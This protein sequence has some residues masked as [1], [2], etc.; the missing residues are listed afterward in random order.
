MKY[1]ILISVLFLLTLASALVYYY[2]PT[3]NIAESGFIAISSVMSGET[4]SLYKKAD[5]VIEFKF[6]DDYGA[7][8]EY[9]L[10][11]WYFTGNLRSSEGKSF[12][13]QFTIF[14]NALSPSELDIESGLASNQVYFAHI[15]ISD[16]DAAQHHHFEKFARGNG[17]LAGSSFDPLN[18]FV[19]NWS[20]S[21]D[22][23]NNDY[24]KPTF[25]INSEI[26]G[27]EIQLNLKPIKDMVL[28]GNN[29]LSPKSNEP[30]NAS[31]YYSFTRIATE[32]T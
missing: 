27:N 32:G 17:K 3:A 30:G 2:I 21:G 31:Y 28:H 1:K 29:G 12:G 8:D 20:I 14:R 10:E 7:H 6:P 26:D 5:K 9:K 15:G 4:D 13:Y 16:I 23:D 24:L 25:N 11:W 18:I 22:Y 19:E